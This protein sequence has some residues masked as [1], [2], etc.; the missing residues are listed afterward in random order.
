MY[1]NLNQGYKVITAH[2]W[3][4]GRVAKFLFMWKT[5]SSP[6]CAS[7][8][9]LESI[10][11]LIWTATDANKLLWKSSEFKGAPRS[12]KSSVARSKGWCLSPAKSR[13][14]LLA[15]GRWLKSLTLWSWT[16]WLGICLSLIALWHGLGGYRHSGRREDTAISCGVYSPV[17]SPRQ[18]QTRSICGG[19]TCVRQQD[20]RTGTTLLANITTKSP[21]LHFLC[22]F[23][24]GIIRASALGV[25]L[26]H[27]CHRKRFSRFSKCAHYVCVYVGGDCTRARSALHSWRLCFSSSDWEKKSFECL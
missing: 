4:T 27:I 21:S 3:Y 9:R 10:L 13:W 20:S 6:L 19:H 5:E 8:L 15:R 7:A 16:H 25:C 12:H 14:P 18:L 11:R 1:C 17:S 26:F 22:I 23:F 2:I 24:G